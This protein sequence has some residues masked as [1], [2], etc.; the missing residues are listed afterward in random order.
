ML[1]SNSGNDLELLLLAIVNL[2]MVCELII[3]TK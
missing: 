3:N 2:L 1:D